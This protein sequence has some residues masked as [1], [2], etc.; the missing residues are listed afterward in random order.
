MPWT[1]AV[2]AT[3]STAMTP[4]S[5]ETS[6]P[7]ASVAARGPEQV[8]GPLRQ[9]HRCACRDGGVRRCQPPNSLGVLAPIPPVPPPQAISGPGGSCKRVTETLSGES[10]RIAGT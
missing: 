2:R 10:P 6:S 1:S 8:R 4:S 7:G 3:G 9:P 5:P